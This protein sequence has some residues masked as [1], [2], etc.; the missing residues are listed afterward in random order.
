VLGPED[1]SYNDMAQIMSKVLGKPIRFQQ[2]TADAHK[3]TLM[4]RG[5]SEAM[6]QGNADMW[7]AYNQGLDTAELRTAES[8]T[9]T[10]FQQWCEEVLKPCVLA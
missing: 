9:P 6:A 10:S 7:T 8:T 5:M 2:I 1:I 4:R 3:S